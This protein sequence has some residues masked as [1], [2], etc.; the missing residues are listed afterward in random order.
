MNVL[1]DAQLH[2]LLTLSWGGPDFPSYEGRLGGGGQANSGQATAAA[3][4]QTAASNQ[5]MQIA[6]QNS[7]LQQRMVGMLFGNGKSGS[8]GTLSQF[9][10][11]NSINQKGLNDNYKTQFNEGSDQ[12]GKDYANQ[13]GALAQQFANSG[14]T[15]SSTPSGF[16]ADQMRKLSG[17]AA[18]ARGSLYSTLKGSQYSDALTNFWNAN[19]LASGNAATALGGANTAAGNSGSSSASI[20]GTAGQYHPS[21]TAG[22]LGSALGAAGS[23]GAGAMMCPADGTL[24]LMANS[25]VK[26]VEDV[27]VGEKVMGIDGLPDE[28][29]DVK[30]AT[31]KVCMVFTT[32]RQVVV[33]DE[34]TFS[35][36]NGGYAF[37]ARSL[38]ESLDVEGEPQLVIEVR[39]LADQKMCRHIMLRRSHGYSCSG[40][41][42]LE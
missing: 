40:F 17:S 28:V 20:Y 32:K 5:E 16:Q 8:T 2:E 15:S 13:R 38:G 33:S 26:K 36:Y 22:V 29:I 7:D 11:P 21:Q 4:Q 10:D 1:T 3:N 18:D 24:I 14:A 35:R 30:P 23:V 12:L 6:K 39:P 42:S 9:L 41:W 19:N 25:T 31:R 37:A 34:H 27:L